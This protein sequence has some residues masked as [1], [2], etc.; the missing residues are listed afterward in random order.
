MEQLKNFCSSSDKLELPIRLAFFISPLFLFTTKSLHKVKGRIDIDNVMQ[1][2]YDNSNI[3]QFSLSF[4][5]DRNSI[6]KRATPH[7]PA[8]G[9]G[10]FHFPL[11]P[12][13]GGTRSN[14]GDER[15]PNPDALERAQRT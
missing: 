11:S 4:R 8:C 3:F 15:L 7:S 6:R 14:Y 1:V 9:E 2:C 13:D 10:D 12:C 5:K